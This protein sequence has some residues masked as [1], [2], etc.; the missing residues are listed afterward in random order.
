MWAGSS[1]WHVWEQDFPNEM[2]TLGMATWLCFVHQEG[3]IQCL[4]CY[5]ATYLLPLENERPATAEFWSTDGMLT[6]NEHR[7]MLR[8]GEPT[9]S[10][11]L[12]VS[13]GSWMKAK[14]PFPESPSIFVSEE[15]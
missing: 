8:P 2:A 4:E 9:G 13:W 1:P 12:P 3:I 11:Q 10:K 15:R 14:L 5:V 7:P 6:Q